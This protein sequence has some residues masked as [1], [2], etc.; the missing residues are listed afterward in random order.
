MPLRDYQDE[1]VQ[2][3][4]TEFAAGVSKQLVV[5][6]TA[7]GKTLIVA[8]AIPR[9]LKKQ[10]DQA[11]F[12][13]QSDE[14]VFQGHDKIQKYNPDLKVGIEKAQYRAEPNDDVVVASIQ[15]IGKTVRDGDDWKYSDR[16][17]KFDPENFRV[18]IFDEAHHLIA[19]QYQSPLRYFQVWKQD[20][21]YDDPSK[22]LLGVTATPNRS[23]SVGL[24]LLFDKIVFSRELLQM[25]E[26]GWLSN[27][28]A[29][30]VD[31]ETLLDEVEVRQGDFVTKQLERV[32][33][34]PGRNR[35][36]VEKYK[37]L[38]EG[39]PAIAFT[40]DVAHSNDLA[41][42]F[43]DAG[44]KAYAISGSTPERDR[45]KLIEM[46]SRGDIDVLVS[47]QA[48]LEGFDAPRASVG[49]FCRP[50][51]SRLMYT[52]SFGRI[53]RPHPAPEE[54]AG[55][56]GWTK[57]YAIAIDFVDVSAKHQLSSVASL[58]GL[59]PKFNLKGK[60]ATEVVKEVERAQAK[61]PGVN[62]TLYN[63][64][65]SLRGVVEK[66]DLFA[67][68]TIPDEVRKLSKLAWVT[69]ISQGA[70]QLCL[71]DKGMLTVKVNTLGQFDVYRHTNGV[72]SQLTVAPNLQ[73]ALSVA[74]ANVPREAA[75]MLMADAN[76]RYEKPSEKQVGL[77]KKLY[78][79]LRRPFNSDEE[80]IVMVNSRYSRGEVSTLISQRI[81]RDRAGAGGRR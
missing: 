13:V 72:R 9:L 60:K 66:I 27:V 3:V 53:L 75:Q 16:L 25:I 61:A 41:K 58:F 49:L 51:K 10:G 37:E 81:D 68:P 48:L 80:F 18:V 79:E 70:Y 19:K 28:K 30:R 73:A 63:D 65:E 12:V 15:T 42:S 64:V 45:R 36:V 78:P 34:T 57:P 77:L 76:W 21:R 31:T 2:N 20:F 59:P 40:V 6:P 74:D 29:Y 24:E 69:G 11:L 46:Y 17:T 55:W 54:A 4:E 71:P 33:N 62:L 7:G 26:S 1:A 52:Q 67:K 14:L 32:V 50:C 23:D 56:K 44:I 43:M 35:L 5:L 8:H 38:G 47:C 22:L 39:M